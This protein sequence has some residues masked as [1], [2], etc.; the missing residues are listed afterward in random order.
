MAIGVLVMIAATVAYNGSTV[1]LA[2]GSRRA[3]EPAGARLFAGVFRRAQGLAGIGLTVVGWTLE[4]L[5][6]TRIPL[7]VSRGIYAGSLGLLLVLA[8]RALHEQV[9]RRDIF[10]AVAVAVGM[11][12]VALSPPARATAAPN[13][14]VWVLLALLLLPVAF[15][16][17]ALRLI[18]HRGGPRISAVA[19]GAGFAG[20]GMFN[21]GI[22]LYLSP[23]LHTGP[24]ALI[25]VGVVGFGLLGFSNEL[26][27]LKYGRA[28]NVVPIILGLQSMLPVIAAPF[29]FGEHWPTADLHR[30][31]LAF[32]LGLA[33][34]GI[35]VLSRGSA[36]LLS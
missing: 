4:V 19:S 21:L 24:L 28:G 16:P 6:L 22:A 18:H 27:A 20:N 15:A 23:S 32:G 3:P 7:T 34:S 30:I 2:I 5:A 36:S 26:D 14:G 1:L 11:V 35:V 31:A 13:P 8:R 9:T 29:M 12:L 17:S 25:L 33:V 10:G